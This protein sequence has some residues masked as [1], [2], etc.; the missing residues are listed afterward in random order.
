MGHN[1][2]ALR[3]LVGGTAE[4]VVLGAEH[5]RGILDTV[6]STTRAA[7]QVIPASVSFR[8]AAFVLRRVGP[9]G[10]RVCVLGLTLCGSSCPGFVLA[11]C[12]RES[13]F[14]NSTGYGC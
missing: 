12:G 9:W 7:Y 6:H 4:E 10:A 1:G 11:V 3:V 2:P 14:R 13:V 8:S 5:V